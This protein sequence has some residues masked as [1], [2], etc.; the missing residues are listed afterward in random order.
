MNEPHWALDP[1]PLSPVLDFIADE[2]KKH[3][4][5]SFPSRDQ[6]LQLLER[7]FWTSL[8]PDEGRFP[9]FSLLYCQPQLPPAGI[10][11]SSG[12]PFER[13]AALA[14]ALA[15]GTAR[16]G[17][18]VGDVGLELWGISL[19]I[20][21]HAVEVRAVGPG[22][23]VVQ[24]DGEHLAVIGQFAQSLV[25]NDGGSFHGGWRYL[26]GRMIAIGLNEQRSIVVGLVLLML[27]MEMRGHRH[28]GAIIV[29]QDSDI[30]NLKIPYHFGPYG[31]LAEEL[32]RL[33]ELEIDSRTV[34]DDI[35]YFLTSQRSRVS[36]H[37]LRLIETVGRLTAVDGALVLSD[38]L[39]V[40]GY[41][42][43]IQVEPDPSWPD[44]HENTFLGSLL[45][46]P[47]VPRKF[48]DL[49][50]TRH[51]SAAFLAATRCGS[52]VSIVASQDGPLSVVFYAN[53]KSAGAI[54]GG[55]SPDEGCVAII[56]HAETLI[57]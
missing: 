13:V 41:G 53:S 37:L 9:T 48:A 23:V 52:A 43:K 3:P 35:H 50:G 22:R 57:E 18:H 33:T 28:G 34:P 10:R 27:A 8:R 1:A 36:P 4:L 24:Y 38:S 12:L 6:L 29:V 39:D 5:N 14:P 49:G 2:Q 26:L 44:P 46:K 55:N 20:P 56:R 7:V 30:S 54:R 15:Q 17:V 21:L 51:Q 19:E 32:T 40:I 45:G 47:W 11:F 42:G 25:V 16:L 31:G